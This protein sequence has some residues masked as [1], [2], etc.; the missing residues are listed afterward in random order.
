LL[1]LRCCRWA[2]IQLDGGSP[3]PAPHPHRLPA[4]SSLAPLVTPFIEQAD[5]A[6]STT[7][8]LDALIQLDALGIELQSDGSK[9]WVAAEDWRRVPAELHSLIRQRSHQLARM[10]GPS[11]SAGPGGQP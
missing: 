6:A 5:A 10:I 8:V 4:V 7:P 11:A 3:R 1:A 2:Q 9:A